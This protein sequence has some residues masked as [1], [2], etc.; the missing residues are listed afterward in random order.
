DRLAFTA[1]DS[2][3]SLAALLLQ[4]EVER[5]PA[6]ELRHRHHEVTPRIAHQ[7]LDITLVVSLAR[8]AIAI[9]DQVMRQEAAEQLRPLAGA[10]GQDLRHKAAVVVVEHRLGNRAEERKGMDVAVNPG[11]GHR[12]RVGPHIARIAVRQV[13]HEEVGL[14]LDAPDPDLRLAEV[15]LSMARRMRQRHKYLLAP[16]FP[17]PNVVLDDRI[18]AGKAALIAKPVE[19]PLGRMPLLARHRTV[20]LQPALDDRDERIKLWPPDL[21]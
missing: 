6:R 10:V 3:L 5:F 20:R 16:P 2:T 19:H 13:Q 12:R 17:L 1:Q 7:T 14:L 9:P 11:L 8:A 4:P 21:G 18:A 15:G